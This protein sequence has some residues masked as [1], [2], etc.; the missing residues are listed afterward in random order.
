MQTSSICKNRPKIRTPIHNRL[1]A[2]TDFENFLYQKR[3]NRR[4]SRQLFVFSLRKP[5]Q[6]T[7]PVWAFAFFTPKRQKNTV[8][9]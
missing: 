7:V 4:A 9:K 3:Q 1:L 2:A 6:T 8:K 5:P